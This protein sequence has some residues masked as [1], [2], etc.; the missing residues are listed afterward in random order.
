M[1]RKQKNPPYELDPKTAQLAEG[2][3][4]LS[5]FIRPRPFYRDPSILTIG[6]GNIPLSLWTS[7]G[8]A[9]SV[10]LTSP[11]DKTCGFCS[12]ERSGIVAMP[13]YVRAQSGG[14][15]CVAFG[16][17]FPLPWIVAR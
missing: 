11:P 15:A 16:T 3:Y 1:S 4:T 8:R 6:D 10:T 17:S 14:A 5:H 13:L 9:A 7:L 12:A 2:E